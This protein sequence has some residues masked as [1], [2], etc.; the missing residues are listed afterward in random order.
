MFP[1]RGSSG[2]VADGYRKY[3]ETKMEKRNREMKKKERTQHK[4]K[5]VV[6]GANTISLISRGSGVVAASGRARVYVVLF[7][8]VYIDSGNT[9]D[10]RCSR[11]TSHTCGGNAIDE[12]IVLW[13]PVF[14]YLDSFFDDFFSRSDCVISDFFFFVLIR[15]FFHCYF[16]FLPRSAELRLT[17]ETSVTV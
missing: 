8:Y 11:H 10:R 12:T 5:T 2:I 14:F 16:S 13:V 3:T 9:A 1:L 4:R 7:R 17:Y 15:I 6:L